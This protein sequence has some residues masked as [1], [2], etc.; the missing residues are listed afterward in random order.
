MN[1]QLGHAAEQIQDLLAE[2]KALTGGCVEYTVV[3]CRIFE[4]VISDERPNWSVEEYEDSTGPKKASMT[5]VLPD[6]FMIEVVPGDKEFQNPWAGAGSYPM[7]QNECEM[8]FPTTLEL[9]ERTHFKNF[10]MMIDTTPGIAEDIR[11]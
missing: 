4:E 9:L 5:M 11:H 7:T 2:D 1:K 10:Y 3:N 8:A 6:C